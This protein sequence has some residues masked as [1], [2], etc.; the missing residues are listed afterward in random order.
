[1]KFQAD[2][3]RT[4]REFAVGTQVFLRLQPYI[5]NSVSRR[6]CHKL[7][8]KFFGPFRIVAR[9]GKVAYRL[10]L[11]PESRVHPVFHVSQLKEFIGRTNQV[12]PVLPSPDSVFQIPVRVLLRRVRQQGDRTL[13]QVKV[14]W[15]GDS[16]DQATWEDLESLRQQFPL[17]P[18]W[19][20]AGSH[21]EGIVSSPAPPVGDQGE[22][23]DNA[24]PQGRPI[25]TRRAPAWLTEG[26]WVT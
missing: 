8:F 18:A 26:T 15:S 10:E 14:Q 7:S 3:H 5:Q 6:T 16:E 1:M 9:V 11:P 25:R 23:L 21:G 12:S 20:Q 2:K 17:A 4:E 19:G 24:A 13:T 22:E